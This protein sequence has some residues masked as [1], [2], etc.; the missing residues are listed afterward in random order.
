MVMEWVEPTIKTKVVEMC[1]VCDTDQEID[2]S[3][4]RF[5]EILN[6]L[7][8]QNVDPVTGGLLEIEEILYSISKASIE[9]SY[10]AGL[11]DG[12]TLSKELL[13]L[14]NK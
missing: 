13:N 14:S 7:K 3:L 6:L 10:R 12:I 9:I 2:R 4:K 1:C 5:I 11:Y 8:S